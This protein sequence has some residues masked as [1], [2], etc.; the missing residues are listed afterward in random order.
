MR[1]T[2]AI[3]DRLLEAAKR[4]ARDQGLTLGQLVEEALRR[5]LGRSPARR[6]R[7]EIPVF[8]RGRGPRPG[9]DLAS[10]RALQE[11]LDED[12]APEHLR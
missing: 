10:N 2:M 6:D 9:V 7:P 8:S 3:D 12:A 1:T 5:E 4:R 11:L